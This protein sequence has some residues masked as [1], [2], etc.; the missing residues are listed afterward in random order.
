MGVHVSIRRQQNPMRHVAGLEIHW[1]VPVTDLQWI[2]YAI[3]GLRVNSMVLVLS[4]VKVIQVCS[5][6]FL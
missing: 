2:L 3:R 6:K 4:I 1:I 5:I